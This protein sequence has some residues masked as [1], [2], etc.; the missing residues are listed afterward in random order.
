MT[1][2]ICAPQTHTSHTFGSCSGNGLFSSTG[3]DH[4]PHHCTN[5]PICITQTWAP[6]C[7]RTGPNSDGFQCP[8]SEREDDVQSVASASRCLINLE[9]KKKKKESGSETNRYSMNVLRTMTV[10][11]VHEKQ[12]T[13]GPQWPA[14]HIQKVGH[15]TAKLQRQQ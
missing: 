7:F 12:S 8:E 9:K 13:S 3:P 6:R 14:C 11:Q 10:Q 15:I 4:I 2:F 1:Q 5:A